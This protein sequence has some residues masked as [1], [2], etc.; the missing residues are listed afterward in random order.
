MKGEL[1]SSYQVED[2]I[3]SHPNVQVSAVLPVPAEVGDEDDI[4]AF[5]V[6]N[7][8][9]EAQKE[10]IDSWLKEQLPKFMWPKYIRF[11]DELPRT[12]SSK[13]EKYKLRELLY[14]EKECN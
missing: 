1:V 7:N 2:Y 3:N 13:I 12:P 11:V 4:A 9:G 8:K 6:L 5:I 14:R 10:E